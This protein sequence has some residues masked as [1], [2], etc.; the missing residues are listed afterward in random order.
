[1]TYKFI[2]DAGHGWL[3]VP[4][5]ELTP[6]M[7]AKISTYS[8]V[9]HTFAYLEEDSDTSIYVNAIGLKWDTDIEFVRLD[10]E[11]IIRSFD[12]FRGKG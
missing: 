3:R 8:Y 6:A 10:G 1:M 4:L 5:N 2:S 9:D 7:R 11:C 12:R